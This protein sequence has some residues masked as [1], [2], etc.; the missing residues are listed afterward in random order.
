MLSA[1]E[2]VDDQCSVADAFRC[3]QCDAG[4]E[5]FRGCNIVCH[6]LL[7]AYFMIVN[8]KSSG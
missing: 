8:F 5:R 3:R 2:G 4:V 1:T 6:N 7:V